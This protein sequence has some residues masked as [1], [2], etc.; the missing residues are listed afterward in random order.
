MKSP[1]RKLILKIRALKTF[2][3]CFTG[4]REDLKLMTIKATIK[5]VIKMV[6]KMVIKGWILLMNMLVMK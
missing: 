3:H 1:V 6:M 2:H 5:M 4:K